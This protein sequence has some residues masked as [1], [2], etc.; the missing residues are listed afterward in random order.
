MKRKTL[1]SL[2]PN[3]RILAENAPRVAGATRRL[4]VAAEAVTHKAWLPE[5]KPPTCETL[6]KFF[7][8]QRSEF[9]SVKH[10]AVTNTKGQTARM[11]NY[12]PRH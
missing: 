12:A 2:Q 10:G 11:E 3:A 4:L 1:I 9:G 7:E 5:L 8:M 6:Q